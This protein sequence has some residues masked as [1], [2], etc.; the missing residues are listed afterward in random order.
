M[1]RDAFDLFG[2]RPRGRFGDDE[3]KPR[4]RQTMVGSDGGGE[5]VSL[6]GRRS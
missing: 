1:S 2:S 6:E 4:N 5:V 3:A